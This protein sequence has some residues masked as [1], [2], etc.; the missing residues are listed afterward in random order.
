MTSGDIHKRYEVIIVGTGAG[1]GTLAYHLANA[2]KRVTIRGTISFHDINKQL[3][4]YP[5]SSLLRRF[6]Y[7]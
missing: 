3:N 7:G 4:L 6:G 5:R 1:G 2:G